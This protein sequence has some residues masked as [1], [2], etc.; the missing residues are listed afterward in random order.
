MRLVVL[1]Y[2]LIELLIGVALVAV[3]VGVVATYK[4]SDAELQLAELEFQENYQRAKNILI[5]ASNLRAQGFTASGDLDNQQLKVATR[6]KPWKA[7]ADQILAIAAELAKDDFKIRVTTQNIQVK[8]LV[9][10]AVG[11]NGYGVQRRQ[12]AGGKD[13]VI[14]VKRAQMK[15]SRVLRLNDYL[16]N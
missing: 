8:F 14:L 5:H 1:G 2:T 16:M 11:L 12:I 3:L 13:Q 6:G 7:S 10:D 15:R 9:D 4:I